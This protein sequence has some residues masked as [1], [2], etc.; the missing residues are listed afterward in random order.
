MKEKCFPLVYLLVVVFALGCSNDNDDINPE[1][2]IA[3]DK[4]LNRL[5][6]G[7][8]AIDLLSNN[9]Y[10]NL[11]IEIAYVEGFR[12][13]QEAMDGFVAYLK[14]RTFKEN[15]ELVYN[16]LA[17]PDEENLTLEEIDDLE[18]ENRTAY[19]NGDTLAI[20]IYFSDA[21]AE[22]DDEAED[23]VTLGA[24]YRN[25]S[26]I[27]HEATV[28]KLAD[29]SIFISDADVESSTL[30]HEFG[31][32]FGLVNLG[33]VP[34]NDHEDIQTD[35]SGEPIL[36]DQGNTM[37]NS[38]CNVTGCL[39]NAELTF[40]GPSSKNTSLT[41]KNEDG[42][43]AGCRLSGKSVLKMLSSQ[44]AKGGLAPDLDSECILDLQTNGGR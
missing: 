30:N 15:I 6:T 27:I 37:S 20:Y 3:V 1:K 35:E 14:E 33:I 4:T 2:P 25:T 19:S 16:E 34:V 22:D 39:M 29:Q 23:L 21:P 36:D 5:G 17:S 10:T 31:H 24:V 12:P 18:N 13:T 9:T 32:L 43:K 26:M 38:H 44:T 11:R 28:R 7:D 42:I 40:G 41:A 8:S